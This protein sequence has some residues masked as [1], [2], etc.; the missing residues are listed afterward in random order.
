MNFAGWN[1]LSMNDYPKKL[2]SIIFVSGC[3][4][5]CS[6]CY[7]STLI[8]KIVHEINE[9]DIFNFFKTNKIVEALV[10]SG[11]EPSLYSKEI[12]DFAKRFKETFPNKF[13]KVDTNGSNL[14][15]AKEALKVFDYIA[16]DFKS[17]DYFAFSNINLDI[18][19]ESLKLISNFKNH[20]VRITV[21]PKYIKESD[22]EKISDLLFEC[23]IKNVSIQQY[24][25]IDN[26]FPYKEDV[27]KGFKD[28][29]V[30]KNFFVTLR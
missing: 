7:N 17:L 18:I 3:N 26:V 15:F 11:G 2:S 9:N 23:G 21:Y 30:S 19:I 13:I 5:S 16:V 8:K 28:I 22:F 12:I 4:F 25:K 27:L 29:L 6:Y 20:E 24:R 10:I 1:Q 14:S